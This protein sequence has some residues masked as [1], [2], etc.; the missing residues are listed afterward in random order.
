M[1]ISQSGSFNVIFDAVPT[2]WIYE[3][4]TTFDIHEIS[5][6][7]S[8]ETRY[9]IMPEIVRYYKCNKALA[10]CIELEIV[11]TKLQIY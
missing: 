6:D 7:A 1:A 3:R 9:K 8:I 5:I 4:F 2:N 11:N 10:A